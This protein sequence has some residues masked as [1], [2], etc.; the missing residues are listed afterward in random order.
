MDD[1][2]HGPLIQRGKVW[3]RHQAIIDQRP[4]QDGSPD[5]RECAGNFVIVDTN[6]TRPF[7]V[8]CDV[9][10]S[11][12]TVTRHPGPATTTLPRRKA[13]PVHQQDSIP[14]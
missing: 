3:R 2:P 6:G 5:P 10:G 11:E 9:C 7:E 1:K 14:F 12:M 4:P 13:Q 8:E